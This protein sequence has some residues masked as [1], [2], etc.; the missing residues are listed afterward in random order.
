[1]IYSY[2]DSYW[3]LIVLHKY[4]KNLKVHETFLRPC[5]KGFVWTWKRKR[6]W[7]STRQ[8]WKLNNRLVIWCFCSVTDK[9]NHLTRTEVYCRFYIL[10]SVKMRRGWKHWKSLSD[11]MEAPIGLAS[12]FSH[13][14]IRNRFCFTF[15]TDWSYRKV[16]KLFLV[17]RITS[18]KEESLVMIKIY[19]NWEGNNSAV[20]DLWKYWFSSLSWE[21]KA[22]ARNKVEREN[23]KRR[24]RNSAWINYEK[25]F[26]LTSLSLL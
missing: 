26:L 24:M 3:F 25:S 14:R 4:T 16:L 5:L 7:S 18:V 20:I 11:F 1:M 15:Y 19:W 10:S 17:D 21:T 2:S 22:A 9:P 8:W 23:G 6:V 12:N 13:L